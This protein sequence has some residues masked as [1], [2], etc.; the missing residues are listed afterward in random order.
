[1]HADAR[2]YVLRRAAVRMA[3]SVPDIST[4]TV[5]Q[6]KEQLRE[7]G[8]PVSGVKAVLIARRLTP[9]LKLFYLK[10]RVR[11]PHLCQREAEGLCD[12]DRAEQAGEQRRD[13]GGGGQDGVVVVESPAKCKTISKFLGARAQFRRGQSASVRNKRERFVYLSRR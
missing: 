4:M 6:L 13:G 7:R 12:D 2:H 10:R 5:P 3:S 9:E 11:R 1:M 8:L